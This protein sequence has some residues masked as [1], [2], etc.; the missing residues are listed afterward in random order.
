MLVTVYS[1]QSNPKHFRAI[2]NLV[3]THSTCHLWQVGAVVVKEK[4]N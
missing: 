1:V 3:K 2:A 4:R